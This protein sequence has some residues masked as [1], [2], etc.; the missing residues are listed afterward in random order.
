MNNDQLIERGTRGIGAVAEFL[1]RKRARYELIEH[2]E[3]FA[4]TEEAHA[5]ATSPARMAKTV[6]LHDHGGFRA[7]VIPASERLDLQKARA[8][9]H[10]SGHLRLASE[11]E[12]EREFPVF[13]AGAMPPFG[14]LLGTPEILD[15]RLLRHRSILCSG[16]DHRH[17]L[18]ISPREI[19][20][21]GEPLVA[22]ICEARNVRGTDPLTDESF[23]YALHPKGAEMPATKKPTTRPRA[24]PAA[25]ARA[26]D[27]ARRLEHIAESLEAAQKDLTS[28]G[29][30]V[31]TGV[32]DLR[33]DVTKMLRDARRDLLKMRRAIQRDL[34]RLQKDVSAAAAAKPPRARPRRTATTRT[35][36]R[37][38]TASSH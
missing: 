24:T 25:R 26:E 11:D 34:D 4:A 16:G 13:D 28:I 17:T 18:K 35:A 19:E 3:T 22:D 30:S 6:L 27:D 23:Q 32:R 7:A 12:I 10:A 36:R 38:T 9:L 5:A 15:P 20:R 1:K 29:G 31:G 8:L 2:P 37:Q 21:L 33:R 14:A